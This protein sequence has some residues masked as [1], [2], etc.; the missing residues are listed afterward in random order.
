M[1]NEYLPNYYPN[2]F[3]ATGFVHGVDEKGRLIIDATGYEVTTGAPVHTLQ[4]Q[5][6]SLRSI[7]ENMGVGFNFVDRNAKTQVIAEIW[8]LPDGFVEVD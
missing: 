4:V 2:S 1:A 8:V 6:A 3:D 7:K 5:F